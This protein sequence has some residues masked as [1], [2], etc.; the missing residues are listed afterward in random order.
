MGWCQNQCMYTPRVGP[1]QGKQHFVPP[2][3][4]IGHELI[5]ALHALRGVLKSGRSIVI[6]GKSTSEEEAAT[7]GLGRYSDDLLTE[8]NLRHDINL[9]Q[10]L[11]YP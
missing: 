3:V 11:S 10:R 8:N 4:T 6:D 1:F 9:P 7:V 5:H 2:A